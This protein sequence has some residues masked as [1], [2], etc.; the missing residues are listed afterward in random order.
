[1]DAE[2]EF[3][4]I[5]SHLGVNFTPRMIKYIKKTTLGSSVE[6]AGGNVHGFVRNSKALIDYMEE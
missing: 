6:A 5:C 1:M 2:V 3:D 4:R